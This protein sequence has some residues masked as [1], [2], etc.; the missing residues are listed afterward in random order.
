MLCLAASPAYAQDGTLFAGTEAAGLF[1]SRDC[2]HTW[3]ATSR[4]QFSTPVNALLVDPDYPNTRILLAATGDGLFISSDGG[5]RWTRR[6]AGGEVL[7]LA[8]LGGP[9]ETGQVLVGSSSG[10]V[11]LTAAT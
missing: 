3:D 7:S 2:G 11:R 4:R 6:W 1:A 8:A 5:K 9:L 10:V